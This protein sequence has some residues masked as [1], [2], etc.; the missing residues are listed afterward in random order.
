MRKKKEKKPRKAAAS[1]CRI[2]LLF[3]SQTS[4]A[5]GRGSFVHEEI[6]DGGASKL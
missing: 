4:V 2:T 5:A 6:P 3:H 1:G